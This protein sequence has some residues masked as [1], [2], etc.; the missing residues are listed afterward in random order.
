MNKKITDLAYA[1][2][3]LSLDIVS[4]MDDGYHNMKMVN[5][6]VT[7]ADEVTVECLPGEGINIKSGLSFLPCDERNIAA[8]A[9]ISF[10]KYTGIKGYETKISMK[11]NIPV[12]AGLGGGSSDG[13][14]VLRILDRMFETNLGRKKLEHIGLSIGADVPFCIDGGTSLA[15]GRGE[16]L[17]NLKPLPKCF[18]VICKPPV[19]IRTPKLFSQIK[20]EKIRARPDTNGII[21]ALGNQDLG[22]VARRMYN[23]FEDVL[24]TGTKYIA[25]IKNIMYDKATLGTVMTGSGPSVIGIFDNAEGAKAALAQL[26]QSYKECFLTEP[27]ERQGY[28]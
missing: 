15:E 13:A 16:M 3:N 14:C 21:E 9:A 19:N 6:T 5:Q 24:T 1:K 28:L 26:K 17:T 12:C 23:V 25:E 4:K 18:I 27:V 7:L 2:V 8:K 22:G 10:F 11:K 20:C